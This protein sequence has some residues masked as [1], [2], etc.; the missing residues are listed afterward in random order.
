[1]LKQ[2]LQKQKTTSMSLL[3]NDLCFVSLYSS[4]G[5]AL[6]KKLTLSERQANFINVLKFHSG[7]PLSPLCCVLELSEFP[8]C[9]YFLKM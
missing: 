9:I 1:M 7:V 8:R 3:F 2:S 4:Y 5:L 6:A